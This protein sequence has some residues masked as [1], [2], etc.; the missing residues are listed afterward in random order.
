MDPD[1]DPDPVILVSDLQDENK[2]GILLLSY[3]YEGTFTNFSKIKSHKKS[4]KQWESRFFL[5]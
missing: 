5:L 4:Q 2:K 3:S 1:V